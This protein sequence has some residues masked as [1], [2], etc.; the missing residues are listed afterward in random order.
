MNAYA[1]H[2]GYPVAAI[3]GFYADLNNALSKLHQRDTTII[4][5]YFNAKIGHA[6]T[7]NRFL[8]NGAVADGTA[9]ATS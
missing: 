4:L 9:M 7:M 6:A 2:S 5:G 8:D 3:D 1:P